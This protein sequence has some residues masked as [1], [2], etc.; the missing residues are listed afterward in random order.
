MSWLAAKPVASSLTAASGADESVNKQSSTISNETSTSILVD[1]CEASCSTSGLISEKSIDSRNESK[2]NLEFSTI[3]S[4]TK[5]ASL[6]TT[7]KRSD[8]SMLLDIKAGDKETRPRTHEREHSKA[9]S[10]AATTTVV[11]AHTRHKHENEAWSKTVHDMLETIVRRAIFSLVQ[12]ESQSHTS[13][14]PRFNENVTKREETSFSLELNLDETL[15]E[16]QHVSTKNKLVGSFI[17]HNCNHINKH[18][19]VTETD[20]K[21]TLYILF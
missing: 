20:G 12:T 7:S 9:A 17:N 21:Y 8:R 2:N 13:K 4:S 18:G 3:S 6:T 1:S 16:G 5:Q 15:F 10:S 14:K 19:V 11:S